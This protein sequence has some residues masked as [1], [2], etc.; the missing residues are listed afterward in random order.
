[1]RKQYAVVC[2]LVLLGVFPVLQ[3]TKSPTGSAAKPAV[4]Q[5]AHPKQP[6]QQTPSPA[7]APASQPIVIPPDASKKANPVTATEKSLAEGK[8]RYTTDCALC[9]GAIGDGKTDVATSMNLKLADF[10]NSATLASR[11]DGDLYYIIAK[12]TGSMPDEGS[13]VKPG[14]IWNLVNYVRTLAEKK[15]A[16]K[17]K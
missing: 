8:A 4:S 16:A 13:R 14:D 1:M 6:M 10:R 17:A 3:K 5:Q 12:G 7:P 15:T 11:T 2:T 9:H